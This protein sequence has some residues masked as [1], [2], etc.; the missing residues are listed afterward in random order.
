M[1]KVV[2]ILLTCFMIV[3][4]GLKADETQLPSFLPSYYAPFFQR[5][6]ETL[7]LVSQSDEDRIK[8]RL[9]ANADNDFTVSLEHIAC[10]RPEQTAIFNN[11]LALI[12]QNIENNQGLF[13]EVTET[14]VSAQVKLADSS[15]TVFSFLLPESVQIWTLSSSLKDAAAFED[16]FKMLRGFVNHQRYEEAQKA[17]NVSM[18]HWRVSISDH[19][20][21]LLAQGKT[22]EAVAILRELLA[23]SPFDYEAHLLLVEHDPESPHARASA[24]VVFKNAEENE[25]ITQAADF[26][27]IEKPVYEGFEVLAKGER[28]LQVILIPLPPCNLWLLEEVAKVFEGM[29]DI[30]VHIRRLPQEWVWGAPERVYRQRDIQKMLVRMR[31]AHIDFTGWSAVRYAEAL[32]EAVKNADAL[33]QYWFGDLVEDIMQEPGQHFVDPYLD[34]FCAL[35]AEQRSDDTRTMYVGITENNIYSGDSNYVFSLGRTSGDSP[36]SILSYYMMLGSTLEEEYATR[37]RLVERIAKEMVPAS[38]KQLGI[39]RSTDPTCPYSY[40]SGIQRLD[41]KTLTLADE[42]KR[43]LDTFRK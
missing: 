40:A 16:D 1:K 31:E 9:Y 29:T 42:L 10:E 4:P 6:G 25:E 20:Q 19:A 18:G 22:T 39:P 38:L 27:G 5:D 13:I 24:R 36:A 14:E 41:Q 15:R 7:N 33:S 21:E 12:T 26:L 43:A 32:T 37:T 35:L 30:P 3:T 28:G 23:T 8:K 11:V 17:G 2:G 34:R